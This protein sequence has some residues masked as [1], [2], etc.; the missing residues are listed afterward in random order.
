MT[1]A[2]ENSTPTMTPTTT[3]VT[4][5]SVLNM[6]LLRKLAL[7]ERSATLAVLLLGCLAV[8]GFESCRY[9]SASSASERTV[10]A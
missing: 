7:L 2:T 3:V 1:K 9:R 5:S 8:L 10:S 6:M 4:T